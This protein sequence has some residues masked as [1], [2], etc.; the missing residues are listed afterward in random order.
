[1]ARATGCGEGVVDEGEVVEAK[2]TRDGSSRRGK[3]IRDV[4]DR[5]GG[6]R[7]R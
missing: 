3:G 7:R 1:M 6:E 4:V 5:G 2:G